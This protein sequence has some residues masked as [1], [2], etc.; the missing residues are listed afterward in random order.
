VAAPAYAALA[1]RPA[2][3][4]PGPCTCLPKEYTQDRMVVAPIGPQQQGQA[5]PEA[6]ETEPAPP[7]L[8]SGGTLL[9]GATVHPARTPAAPGFSPFLTS[10]YC[11]VWLSGTSERVPLAA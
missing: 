2:A 6:G 3:A 9:P 10:S 5:Q 11:I 7:K 1:P 8:K 4:T